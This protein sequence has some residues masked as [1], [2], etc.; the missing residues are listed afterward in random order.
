MWLDAP[1]GQLAIGFYAGLIKPQFDDRKIRRRRLEII[2]QPQVRELHFSS[3]QFIERFAEMDQHQV[4]LMSEHGVKRRLPGCALL[5][6]FQNFR[7][8]ICNFCFLRGTQRPPSLPAKAE[9]LMQDAVALNGERYRRNF[10]RSGLR[11]RGAGSCHC[12]L[13]LY[14]TISRSLPEPGT[15][16]PTAGRSVTFFVVIT[17]VAG[18]NFGG[19][20][21]S[22]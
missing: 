10:G 18:A 13:G 6:F 1:L 16:Y 17:T 15:P 4:A 2:A 14:Q 12:L 9:H 3:V 20:Q 7:G 5:P 11:A 19:G 21:S 22:V 8:F